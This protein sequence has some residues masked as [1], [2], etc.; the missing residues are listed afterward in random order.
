MQYLPSPYG[1]CVPLLHFPRSLQ[2]QDIVDALHKSNDYGLPSNKVAEPVQELS[3][4]DMWL[5]PGVTEHSL[6]VHLLFT[7]RACLLLSHDAPSSYAELMEY[8]VAG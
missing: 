2:A 5:L 3:I 1:L 6:Q 4:H 8:M 7:V